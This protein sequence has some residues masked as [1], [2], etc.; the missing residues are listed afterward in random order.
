MGDRTFKLGSGKTSEPGR[1]VKS[2]REP[3]WREEDYRTGIQLQKALKAGAKA[4]V[5]F[6]RNESGGQRFHRW[7][8]AL[9]NT[10]DEGLSDLFAKGI[11]A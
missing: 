5:L 3:P 1:Y 8:E 9:L 2:Q 7:V 6:G 10:D 11:K 4:D